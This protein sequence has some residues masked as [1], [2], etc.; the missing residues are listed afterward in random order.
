MNKEKTKRLF[1]IIF[2]LFTILNSKDYFFHNCFFASFLSFFLKNLHLFIIFEYFCIFFKKIC[3][4]SFL[5]F[6]NF[7]SFKF[8]ASHFTNFKYFAFFIKFWIF[9]LF[10]PILYSKPLTHFNR[11]VLNDINNREKIELTVFIYSF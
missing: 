2:G 11:K 5:I 3:I 4:F 1:L 7:A 8:I 9:F 6:L 10:F